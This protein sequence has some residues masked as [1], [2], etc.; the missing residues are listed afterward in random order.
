MATPDAPANEESA[1]A[2]K[3]VGFLVT[4]VIAACA[5][6]CGLTAPFV[7]AEL[8]KPAAEETEGTTMA[9]P[10]VDEE[11]AYIAFDEVTVNLDEARFSRFLRLKFSLQVAK[12]Q[13]AEIEAMVEEKSVV[14]K[15]WIQIQ[16]AE[17]GTED[18]QGKFGRNRI[19]RELQDFFNRVL[20][21]D[22]IERIQDVL[23]DEFQV[24]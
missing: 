8:A 14:F 20:F 12:S 18:L 24:Q 1:P 15:N 11:V 4:L 23:F 7:V 16:L 5:I 10:E 22:G 13:K 9:E 3:G 6:V 21:D 2:K 19:R 17:K